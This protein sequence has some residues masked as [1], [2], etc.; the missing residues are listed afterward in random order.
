MEMM[1]MWLTK[2]EGV[3][4]DLVE[5]LRIYEVVLQHEDEGADSDTL[6]GTADNIRYVH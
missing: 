3:D 1:I 5:Q 6:S 2:R 4:A